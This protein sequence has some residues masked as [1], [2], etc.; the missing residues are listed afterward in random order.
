MIEQEK[1]SGDA[2]GQLKDLADEIWEDLKNGVIDAHSKF[3]LVV[4][5]C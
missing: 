3:K 2:G 5:V 4:R 1:S